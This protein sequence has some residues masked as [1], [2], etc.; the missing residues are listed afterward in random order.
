MHHV[1]YIKHDYFGLIGGG[2]VDSAITMA[3]PQRT[4]IINETHTIKEKQKT[5]NEITN[6]KEQN[7]TSKRKSINDR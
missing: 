2:G 7:T 4:K 6:K 1:W 5:S 3:T